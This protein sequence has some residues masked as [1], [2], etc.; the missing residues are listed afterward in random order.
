MKNGACALTGHRSL[1]PFFNRRILFDELESLIKK[2]YNTFFCGMAEGFDLISLQ[3]L[4]ELKERYPIYIEACV[5]FKGQENGFSLEN[6]SLYRDLI[7]KCDRVTVLF[8]RY[9]NGCYLVRDRYM[10]DCS[11]LIFAYCTKNEGGTAYTV[12]YALSAQKSVLYSKADV[13]Y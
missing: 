8:E 9:K 5:P 7:K 1:P 2:G 3:L 6:R 12:R 4:I 10:V 13:I 11:D